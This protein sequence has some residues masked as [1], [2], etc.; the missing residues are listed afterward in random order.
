MGATAH[1]APMVPM[2]STMAPGSLAKDRPPGPA[3]PATSGRWTLT[4]AS[5]ALRA[6]SAS[7]AGV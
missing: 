2:A 3:M 6:A 5:P 7:R 1:F 4:T